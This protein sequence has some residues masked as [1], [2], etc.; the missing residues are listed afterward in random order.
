MGGMH[1]TQAA[2]R[3]AS[4]VGLRDR[5]KSRKALI[6]A[7]AAHNLDMV[8]VRNSL[9]APTCSHNWGGESSLEVTQADGNQESRRGRFVD[10]IKRDR[11]KR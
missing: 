9:S 5:A 8:D 10:D 11:S 3:S 4:L 1:T 2:K 6:T 7:H